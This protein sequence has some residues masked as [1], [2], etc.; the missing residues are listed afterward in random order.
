MDEDNEIQCACGAKATLLT[1]HGWK[2][3]D[4][5][6]CPKCAWLA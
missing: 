4:A 5:W 1:N 3:T 2:A 6:W